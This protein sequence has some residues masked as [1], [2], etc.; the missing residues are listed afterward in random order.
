MDGWPITRVPLRFEVFIREA[1]A[2]PSRRID[3]RNIVI[4]QLLPGEPARQDCRFC[5]SF[6][7]IFLRRCMTRE[8]V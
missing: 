3:E 4:E 8:F 2:P 7:S 5:E 1:E 6:L